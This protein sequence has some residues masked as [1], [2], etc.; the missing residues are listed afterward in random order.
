MTR[1]IS[2]LFTYG[3][4]TY[5]VNITKRNKPMTQNNIEKLHAYAD[6]GAYTK[7]TIIHELA[8]AYECIKRD[9]HHAVVNNYNHDA[10]YGLRKALHYLDAAIKHTE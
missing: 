9:H 8:R 2:D 4:C 3:Y 1:A 6:G 10:E 5:E 7:T